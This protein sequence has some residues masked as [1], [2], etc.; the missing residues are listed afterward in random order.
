MGKEQ[1]RQYLA[2]VHRRY[3]RA[4][5][6]GRARL[7]D[8]F[9]E[10]SGYHRKYAIRLLN[11]PPPDLVPKKR[12]PRGV[13]YGK[14]VVQALI[15]IWTAAGYPWSLRLKALLPVWL[16][17]LRNRLGITPA[18]EAQILKI[19]ARQIDRRLKDHK[20]QA[21]RR[22]YGRTKPGTLLKHQ[23]PIKTEHWDVKTPGFSEVDLVSHSGSKS[24][25][26]FIHSM[27]LTDILTTWVETRAV[28]GKGEAGVVAAIDDIRNNLP[29]ALV[30][31]DSDNGSEFVNHHLLRYCKANDIQLTRGRPYKKDDNAHI[32]QKN[33][34]H[35]RKLLGY[36]RYDTRTALDAI[37]DL[38][39]GDL[40]L[41]QN[42]FLPSV[43]LLRKERVGSKVR[44]HYD[45]AR[46][47][48]DRVIECANVNP[49]MVER[50]KA[51]RAQLDPFALSASV[52]RQIERIYELASN[53]RASTDRAP[54]LDREPTRAV[55]ADAPDAGMEKPCRDNGL[56]AQ[57]SHPRLENRKRKR[58]PT[59][60]WKTLRVSH[61]AHRPLRFLV[62]FSRRQGVR[63]GLLSQMA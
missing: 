60:A 52:D 13:F 62:S 28:M 5:R 20:R 11:G 2:S 59:G 48:L 35:V 47:P 32:E 43:K 36:V 23:I 56:P 38:Y 1:R 16:P 33:W 19:S 39:K 14:R 57:L 26:D 12:G 29:F 27:N 49:I 42:L 54:E 58:F 7:L 46:T 18:I 55:D 8:E 50:L 17:K 24:D 44:R 34:T 40:R 4:G 63:L 45:K 25:G 21:K 9:C 3:R 61:S 53:R 30:G 41:L 6:H 22:L 15:E 31:V 10:D 51:L 37:N